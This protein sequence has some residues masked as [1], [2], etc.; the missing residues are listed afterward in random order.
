[1][2]LPEPLTGK[3]VSLASASAGAKAT[4]VMFICNH[5]PFVVMLLQP[6]PFMLFLLRAACRRYTT[7]TT[8]K[9]TRFKHN[10]PP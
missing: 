2:Q 5:C 7:P 8:S 6:F 1:L 3:S 9:P 4:L 10:T